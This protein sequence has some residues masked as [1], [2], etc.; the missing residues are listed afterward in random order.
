MLAPACGKTVRERLVGNGVVDGVGNVQ[1][2][3]YALPRGLASTTLY[4][5]KH[6]SYSVPVLGR[7]SF[8]FEL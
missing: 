4:R 5:L 7:V 1:Q 8:T 2:H 3:N 6:A